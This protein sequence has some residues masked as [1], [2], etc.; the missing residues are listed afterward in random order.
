MLHG[1]LLVWTLAWAQPIPGSDPIPGPGIGLDLSMTLAIGGAILGLASFLYTI[2]RNRKTDLDAQM[3]TMTKGLRH[4]DGQ[5]QTLIGRANALDQRLTAEAA[6]SSAFDARL[7]SAESAMTRLDGA[8]VID[9]SRTLD[10]RM[11]VVESFTSTMHGANLTA[12]IEGLERAHQGTSVQIAS[13]MV[14]LQGI[15]RSL[16]TLRQDLKDIP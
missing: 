15:L 2:L 16:E 14:E 4:L 6:S 8:G 1:I 11:A 3:E 10:R 9:A 5:I 12:R 13:A 7:R